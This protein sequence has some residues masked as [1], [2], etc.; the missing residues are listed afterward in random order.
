M[1]DTDTLIDLQNA[2]AK[3]DER[4]KELEEALAQ[5]VDA[6][7]TDKSLESMTMLAWTHGMEYPEDGKLHLAYEAAK[8]LLAKKS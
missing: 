6:V 5:I 4:I 1:T 7:D 8:K 2:L 3:R